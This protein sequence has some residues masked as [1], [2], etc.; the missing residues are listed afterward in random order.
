MSTNSHSV[1]RKETLESQVRHNLAAY[2]AA[3]HSVKG[4]NFTGTNPASSQNA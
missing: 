3:Y 2:L 4:L 1:S